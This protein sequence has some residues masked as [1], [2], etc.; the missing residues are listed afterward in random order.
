MAP[1]VPSV[2]GR[3]LTPSSWLWKVW[4]SLADGHGFVGS[5]WWEE[6]ILH[7]KYTKHIPNIYQ[8]YTKDTIFKRQ[9]TIIWCISKCADWDKTISGSDAVSEFHVEL[10]IFGC[11][12][13]FLFKL[14]RLTFMSKTAS[15]KHVPDKVPRAKWPHGMSGNIMFLSKSGLFN[16]ICH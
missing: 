12:C 13:F 2:G 7:G 5:E 15:L 9:Q 4:S 8:T 16:W 14:W 11:Y 1:A 10:D 6:E 3:V